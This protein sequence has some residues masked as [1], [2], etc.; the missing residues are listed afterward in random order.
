MIMTYLDYDITYFGE[1]SVLIQVKK[2]PSTKLLEWLS[3]K[4]KVLSKKFNVEVIQT[5]NELLLKDIFVKSSK[6]TIEDQIHS[7]LQ[8]EIGSRLDQSII[9]QIPVCYDPKY[10]KDILGYSR[11]IGLSLQEIIKLHTSITYTIYFMGFLPGF[12]Y[13]EGLDSKLYLARKST[14]SRTIEAGSVAIGG[15]QTGI[16]PQSS[17]GGWYCIGRTPIDLF[18]SSSKPHTPFKTG[19]RLE[20][21]AIESIQFEEMNMGIY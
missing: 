6:N 5:Y 10:A 12:P 8:Q 2:T 9:H 21:Y 11:G 1:S 15:S 13:L 3:D 4:K 19:D 18:N 17:P 14:P 20:F 16:Y 7:L